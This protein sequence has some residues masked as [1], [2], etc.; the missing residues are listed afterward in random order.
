[1]RPG[2]VDGKYLVFSNFDSLPLVFAKSLAIQAFDIHKAIS[3]DGIVLNGHLSGRVFGREMNISSKAYLESLVSF[4]SFVPVEI[5]V[6][7]SFVEDVRSYKS[8]LNRLSGTF[9]NVVDTTEDFVYHNHNHDLVFLPGDFNDSYVHSSFVLNTV[10]NKGV[11]DEGV[12]KQYVDVFSILTNVKQNN[13]LLF[14]SAVPSFKTESGLDLVDIYYSD[15]SK[16]VSD[17]AYLE[18]EDFQLSK[19]LF[20][21]LDDNSGFV[22]EKKHFGND[23][24]RVF[25]LQHGFNHVL[26]NFAPQVFTG[27]SW[28]EKPY[29]FLD[30]PSIGRVWDFD[31]FRSGSFLDEFVYSASDADNLLG[32]LVLVNNGGV[33]YLPLNFNRLLGSN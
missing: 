22:H 28:G 7:P 19:E 32:S 18:S 20:E 33:K 16:S 5:Y 25:C 12:F 14:S 21:H 15:S 31:Y 26:V 4:F 17:S 30:S 8:V 13:S 10:L 29:H 3:L 2:D 23:F 11:F 27:H 1:M 24:F 9:K 6:N